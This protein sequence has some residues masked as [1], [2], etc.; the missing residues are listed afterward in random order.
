MRSMVS[1]AR[2]RAVQRSLHAVNGVL[3]ALDDFGQNRRHAGFFQLLFLLQIFLH[4]VIL[5]T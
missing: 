2:L 3:L 1:I 5:T 4:A